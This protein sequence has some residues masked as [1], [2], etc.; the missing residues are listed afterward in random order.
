MG[1][2]AAIMV[3]LLLGAAV[4]VIF[5]D[6]DV[7]TGCMGGCGMLALLM[8]LGVFALFFVLMAF[9]CTAAMFA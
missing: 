2:I 3:V 9:A 1:V 6:T 7:V 4:M 5:I 8:T